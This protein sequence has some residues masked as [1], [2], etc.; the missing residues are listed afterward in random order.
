MKSVLTL[1][2]IF[3]TPIVASAQGEPAPSEL[4]ARIVH[5]EHQVTRNLEP[6][7]PIVETYIQV[8]NSQHGQ[9]SIWYDRDYMSVADFVG[10]PTALRFKSR[11]GELWRSVSGYSDSLR[12]T[13]MEYYP[14]GFVAM[15]YPEPSTFDL[16]H[17][18]FEYLS[19]ESLNGLNCLVLQV[20]PSTPHKKGLFEGKIWVETKH[21]TIIRFN[22]IYLGSSPSQKYVHFDSWRV[23]ALPGK[24]VPAG[25]YS[26]EMALPCCGV[27][28][29]NWA[30]I[31]FRAQ[32][33]FWGYDSPSSAPEI[34]WTR[35]AVDFPNPVPSAPGSYGALVPRGQLQIGEQRPENKV[36]TRLEELGLLA[37]AGEVDKMLDGV[38][39]N[40]ETG[41]NISLRSQVHCRIL[42]TSNLES[43][44]VGHTILLSRGFIDTVPSETALAAVLAHDL[45]LAALGGSAFTDSLGADPTEISTR[46]V[47]QRFHFEPSPQA[48][49]QASALAHEWMLNSPYK[50][51]LDSVDQFV[52]ELRFYSPHIDQ[53]LK[54]LIGGSVYRAVCAGRQSWSGR[55]TNGRNNGHALALGSRT[56]LN[57]WNNALTLLP[58]AE[59]QHSDSSDTAFALTPFS[60]QFTYAP[61]DSPF[62]DTSVSAARR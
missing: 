53:L 51:S 41:N 17:Y 18:R 50:D 2:L 14:S 60:I 47:A 4:A 25:I 13:A 7:H 57:P 22:G 54:P 16:D 32:T 27:W 38:V 15:A 43:S 49:Q 42:L 40:I 36:I 56:Q 34:S 28:K 12:P 5:R 21:F 3:L 37:P 39:T 20:S 61:S 48:E 1:F 11:H 44:V 9:M 62:G 35:I 19:N 23:E 33:R 26:Q 58:G 46:D 59:G 55:V 29:L 31:R 10:G 6:Y 8:M 52:A 30:K 45:A 24:W